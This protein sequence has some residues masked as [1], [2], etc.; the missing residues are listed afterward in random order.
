MNIREGQRMYLQRQVNG[1]PYRVPVTVVAIPPEGG[2]VTVQWGPG[3][4]TTVAT[5]EL[6]ATNKKERND[7]SRVK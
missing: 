4:E 3:R 6:V 7:E 1:K 2:E 5:A